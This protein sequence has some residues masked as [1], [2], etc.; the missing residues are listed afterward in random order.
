MG[1]FKV[2][3]QTSCPARRPPPARLR[4]AGGAG[5]WHV[6]SP[7]CCPSSLPMLF[8]LLQNVCCWRRG[9]RSGAHSHRPAGPHQ[10]AVPGGPPC[11]PGCYLGSGRRAYWACKSCLLCSSAKGTALFPGPS[12]QVKQTQTVPMPA[13]TSPTCRCKPCHRRAP[14]PQ[15]TQVSARRLARS[16]RR[17]GCAPF[18]RETRSTSSG[19]TASS[20]RDN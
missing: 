15:H 9:R 11:Y 5:V 6:S 13:H 16:L 4:R 2:G 18:G 1:Q 20:C 10:A 8:R 19:R 17:R 7:P 14:V 3:L 12:R